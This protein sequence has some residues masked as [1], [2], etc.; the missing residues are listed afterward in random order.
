MNTLSLKG[1]K[2]KSLCNSRRKLKVQNLSARSV[3]KHYLVSIST[4]LAPNQPC[5]RNTRWFPKEW[6]NRN[7]QTAVQG[8]T[9]TSRYINRRKVRTLIRAACRLSISFRC[10]RTGLPCL[11]CKQK[12]PNCSGCKLKWRTQA[13]SKIKSR[14]QRLATN[15]DTKIPFATWK[16]RNTISQTTT[17]PRTTISAKSPSITRNISFTKVTY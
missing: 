6:V 3:T 5:L 9:S 14:K 8:K 16:N 13:S 2:L 4:K 10:P 15:L 12:L 17:T 1:C 7:T 11:K